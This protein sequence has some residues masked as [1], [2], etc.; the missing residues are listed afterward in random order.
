MM[1]YTPQP[2]VPGAA[3]VSA[4]TITILQSKTIPGGFHTATPSLAFDSACTSGS[5]I[6]VAFTHEDNTVTITDCSD[7]TNGSYGTADATVLS[8]TTGAGEGGSAIYSKNNT[9]TTALTISVPLSASAFGSITIYE[10]YSAT[11]VAKD[12]ANT[13]NGVNTTFTISDT[14]VAAHCMVIATHTHYPN[15]STNDAGYTLPFT[16]FVGSGS[17]HLTEHNIDVGAAGVQTLTMGLVGLVDNWGFVVSA[18]KA[19]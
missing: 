19:V 14:T 16:D 9:A 17:H 2:Q 3:T 7:P 8:G 15:P 18:Y 1:G 5:R 4:A 13:A 6:V 10:L 12:S 11:G